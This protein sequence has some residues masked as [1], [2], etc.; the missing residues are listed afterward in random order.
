MAPRPVNLDADHWVAFPEQ[1][2]RQ[3]EGGDCYEVAYFDD[4]IAALRYANARRGF[5]AIPIQPGQTIGD[6]YTRYIN[7]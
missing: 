3:G 1:G 5:R 2:A 4:E 7:G 6:A